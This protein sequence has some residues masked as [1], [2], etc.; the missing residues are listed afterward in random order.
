MNDEQ[1]SEPKLY[2]PRVMV[3]RRV[4]SD[5]EGWNNEWMPATT[6]EL[7]QALAWHIETGVDPPEDDE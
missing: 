5:A 2:P 1:I 6:T 7:L 4:G 3:Y